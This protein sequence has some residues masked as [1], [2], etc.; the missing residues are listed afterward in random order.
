VSVS[1]DRL[2]TLRQFVERDPDDPRV[3]YFLASELHKAGDWSGAAEQYAA[4]FALGASDEGYGYRNHAECLF[5]TGRAEEARVACE[6]G[7]E[8]ALAHRHDGL[9]EE[10]RSVLEDL[11]G[12]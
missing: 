1:T 8:A 7:I 11:G 12:A 6:R 9:A 4:Y 3:R 10:I 5:R 2:E